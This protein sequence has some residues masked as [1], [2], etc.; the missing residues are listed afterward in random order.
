MMAAGAQ[1]R[2]RAAGAQPQ[3][4]ML[5][6][7]MPEQSMSMKSAPKKKSKATSS[8]GGQKRLNDEVSS[9]LYKMSKF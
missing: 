9:K 3:M 5:S 7:Q 4:E 1:P 2:M 8:I 6:M